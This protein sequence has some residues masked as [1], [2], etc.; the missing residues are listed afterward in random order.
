[1]ASLTGILRRG[2]AAG[3]IRYIQHSKVKFYSV[4][5]FNSNVFYFIHLQADST[6]VILSYSRCVD[7]EKTVYSCHIVILSIRVYI[8]ILTITLM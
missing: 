2:W 6:S 7:I 4:Q 1:M 5:C 8:Y 3:E